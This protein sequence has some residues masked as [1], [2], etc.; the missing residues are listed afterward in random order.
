M[1]DK[2]YT[3]HLDETEKQEHFSAIL[4]CIRL[5]EI[6]NFPIC[7]SV[8]KQLHD[9]AIYD[10]LTWDKLFEYFGFDY[11][12]SFLD[13]YQKI[14]VSFSKRRNKIDL[15]DVLTINSADGRFPPRYFEFVT[16]SGEE[17]NDIEKV[18]YILK[19]NGLDTRE[20]KDCSEYSTVFENLASLDAESFIRV[21][22]YMSEY[23]FVKSPLFNKIKKIQ[24]ANIEA[25]K[26]KKANSEKGSNEEL[27]LKQKIND[28]TDKFKK[29]VEEKEIRYHLDQYDDT[30]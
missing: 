29:I 4:S 27:K 6:L 7:D 23:Y 5:R 18:N 14:N 11:F 13:N 21:L 24:K 25:L 16:T 20:T 28:L 9:M 26:E 17:D 19:I 12:R 3:T 2:E 30:Y 22:K 8:I 15:Q 10:V 1:D